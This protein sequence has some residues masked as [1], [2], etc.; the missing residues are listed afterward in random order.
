MRR[1]SFLCCVL[2]LFVGQVMAHDDKSTYGYIEKVML[3]QQKLMISAKLDTGA[4]SASLN[5]INISD[6]DVEGKPYLRFTVPSTQGDRVFT[7]EYV[8]QVNIKLRAGEARIARLLRKSIRRPV[9]R[10]LIQ[11]GDKTREVH[12]NLTNRKRF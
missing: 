5:A 10:M 3:V 9:V 8:G 1:V 7:C 11:L 6:V 2:T 12:V 4:K